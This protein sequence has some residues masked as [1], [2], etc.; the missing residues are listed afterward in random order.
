MQTQSLFIGWRGRRAVAVGLIAVG[1]SVGTCVASA[2]ASA[3]KPDLTV[4]ALPDAVLQSGPGAYAFRFAATIANR[5]DVAAPGSEMRFYLS[6]DRR[7]SSDDKR[8]PLLKV[9]S[10]P[11]G[12]TERVRE[13]WKVPQALAPGIYHVLACADVGR[14]VAE[15]NERN[16]CAVARG[17]VATTERTG[18][19]AQGQ[20]SSYP[21]AECSGNEP[22][23]E[24][25]ADQ[26]VPK[27]H[28]S[29][30][31]PIEIFA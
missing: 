4:S 14:D 13:T 12:A 18:A 28:G 7:L 23:V 10:L 17:T 15:S 20:A 16:N 21:R 2:G 6:A 27:I 30:Q 1:L 26:T 31:W 5:G 3:A 22:Y 11:A 25:G 8:I 24:R 29:M 9:R 19:L